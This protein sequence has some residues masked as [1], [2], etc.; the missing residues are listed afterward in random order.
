MIIGNFAIGSQKTA[1]RTASGT[2]LPM[3]VL[4]S[5]LAG[6]LAM[7]VMALVSWELGASW[8]GTIPHD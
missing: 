4:C 8:A 3:I 7:V 5:G 2:F 6:V 1:K